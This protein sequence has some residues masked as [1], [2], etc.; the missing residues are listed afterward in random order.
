VGGRYDRVGKAV[1][2]RERAFLK[3]KPAPLNVGRADVRI[4]LLK[5]PKR[6]STS[7]RTNSYPTFPPALEL[8]EG[9][10]TRVYLNV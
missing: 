4:T 2:A 1:G 5:P 6:V 3:N 9:L 10:A 7:E 8:E